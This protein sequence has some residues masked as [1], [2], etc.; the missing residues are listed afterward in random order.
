VQCSNSGIGRLPE[1]ESGMKFILNFFNYLAKS[2]EQQLRERQ[3]AYLAQSADI[4]D[5]EYRMREL[6]RKPQH[7]S[8]VAFP[9]Q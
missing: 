9:R 1:K 3:E 6:A 4:S 2:G 7:F 8:W 5:L